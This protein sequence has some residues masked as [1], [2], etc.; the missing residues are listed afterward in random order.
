[1]KAIRVS[2]KPEKMDDM[3]YLKQAIKELQAELK[4]QGRELQ[5]DIEARELVKKSSDA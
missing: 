2:K 1:M 4:K 5:F 3:T